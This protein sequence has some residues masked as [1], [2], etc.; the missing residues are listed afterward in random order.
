MATVNPTSSYPSEGD[1]SIIL[2]TWT[3]TSTNT[4]GAPICVPEWADKTWHNYGTWGGATLTLQGSNEQTF[5]GAIPMTLSNAASGSAGTFTANG[6]MCSL[7]NTLWVRPN[8]TTAGSGA[9]V[10]ASVLVRLPTPLRT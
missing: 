7:E 6:G 8:L 4:D 2:Y 5:A 1:E 3:L 9:T 10:T